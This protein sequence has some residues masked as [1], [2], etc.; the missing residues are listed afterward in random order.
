MSLFLSAIGLFG[1][2]WLLHFFIIFI[3]F[4]NK[5]C[6]ASLILLLS[7]FIMYLLILLICWFTFLEYIDNS[8]HV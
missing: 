4:L 2:V 5:V 8:A 3:V 6:K 1:E 7:C